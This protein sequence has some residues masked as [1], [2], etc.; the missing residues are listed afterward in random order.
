MRILLYSTSSNIF[1]P[2]TAVVKNF[3]SSAQQLEL[4]AKS[5][6]EH[7]FIVTTQFP[8]MFLLD[9]NGSENFQK[10]NNVQYEIIKS[11]DESEI[12]DFLYSLNPE[13][14]IAATF[15]VT[16]FD[17]LTAKD[18]LVAD[19]LRQKGIKTVCHSVKTALT[20]FDKWQ[21]HQ[22]LLQLKINTPKA[23]Y[24]NHALFINAGNRKTVKSNVYK[25]ALLSEIK[26]LNFP[27]V[28]KDTTGLSSYGMDVLENFSQVHDWLRSK[29][30]TSDRIVEEFIKGEQFGT[31]IESI[32]SKPTQP[33]KN[34]GC[35]LHKILPP[36]IFSVNKYGITSPK[37]SVKLGPVTKPEYKME[38]LNK[39]LKKIAE[40]LD[41]EGITQIDLVF[42]QKKWFVIEIN[43]RL[44]GMTASYAAMQNMTIFE[45][46]LKTAGI[47]N[48]NEQKENFVLNIKFPLLTEEE[49]KK[50]SKKSFVKQVYQTENLAAK[51]EREK[52]YCEVILTSP[53]KENL[54]H[55]IKELAEV[56][57]QK[58]EKV[59]CE[60]ALELAKKI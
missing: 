35:F 26:K 36:M 6:P 54:S 7:S 52:G 13:I 16:P 42:A 40:S 43:P 4:L 58:T 9:M 37:Q 1:E 5:F 32:L 11:D 59:F 41:F 49:M 39:I 15:F 17:W 8:G 28:I 19:F 50:L 20:C 22:K 2:K 51:Q 23:L 29:K 31:E 10:A 14:A 44:S 55:N 48:K 24:I 57:P 18:A 60:T 12:A 34:S 47:Q 3:P 27:V 38:E 21:T 45:R 25:T 46:I 33:K 53:A 30:F 56:L